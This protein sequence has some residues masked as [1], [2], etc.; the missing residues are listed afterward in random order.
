VQVWLSFNIA[1]WYLLLLTLLAVVIGL[2]PS[3][4]ERWLKRIFHSN[5]YSFGVLCFNFRVSSVNIDFENTV[6]RMNR[7]FIRFLALF[8]VTFLFFNLVYSFQIHAVYITKTRPILQFHSVVISSLNKM[9]EVRERLDHPS[10]H[11]H[12]SSLNYWTNSNK[13]WRCVHT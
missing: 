4:L 5:Y 8:D 1:T 6:L 10:V 7:I 3:Q 2:L 9:H 11:P 12:V 13:T